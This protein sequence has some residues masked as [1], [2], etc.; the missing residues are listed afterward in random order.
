MKQLFAVLF[1]I[2]IAFSAVPAFACGGHDAEDTTTASA[3]EEEQD[4]TK[5]K[6][7]DKK[8]AK[9]D[10]DKKSETPSS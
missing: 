9:K 1:A 8:Q 10:E 2:A 6:K 4:Q 3:G 5:T 7:K